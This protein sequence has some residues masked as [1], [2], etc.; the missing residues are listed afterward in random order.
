MTLKREPFEQIMKGKKKT[1]YRDCSAFWKSRIEN[2]EYDE[3]LF[4]NGYSKK[5]AVMRIEFLGFRVLKEEDQ[6]A[7]KLG[8]IIEVKRW[9]VAKD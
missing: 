6:Y 9:K 4:Q 8:K 5:S 7:I 1:E 3:I 2:R